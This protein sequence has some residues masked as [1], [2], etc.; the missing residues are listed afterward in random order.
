[1]G[2]L[3]SSHAG[4]PVQTKDLVRS[5][6]RIGGGY[7][8][9]PCSSHRFVDGVPQEPPETGGMWWPRVSHAHFQGLAAVNEHW[10]P[11]MTLALEV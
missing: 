3:C 8:E 5:N 10:L 1:M 11:I 4:R 2:G 9:M 7:A 6:V